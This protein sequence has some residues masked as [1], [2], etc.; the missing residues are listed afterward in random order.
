MTQ[1][2]RLVL[3]RHGRMLTAKEKGLRVRDYLPRGL[4]TAVTAA[5]MV[6]ALVT[7]TTATAGLR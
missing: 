5:A 3:L 6:L 1:S 7:V 2:V 4:A